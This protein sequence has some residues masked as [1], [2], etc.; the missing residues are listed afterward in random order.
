MKKYVFMIARLSEGVP[1]LIAFPPE[2]EADALAGSCVCVNPDTSCK[3]LPGVTYG[4]TLTPFTQNS[5][6]LV[7]S[8]IM[9][10]S[11]GN[12]SQG[13]TALN[14]SDN[15]EEFSVDTYSELKEILL[16]RYNGDLSVVS[17][18]GRNKRSQEPTLEKF[19]T[20]V[21]AQ[22]AVDDIIKQDGAYR[23]LPYMRRSILLLLQEDSSIW[24]VLTDIEQAWVKTFSEGATAVRMF[25]FKDT[26]ER[27]AEILN[28]DIA[29][30]DITTPILV[31]FVNHLKIEETSEEYLAK[32]KAVVESRGD[33]QQA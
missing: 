24:S 28:K 7:T 25:F 17:F 6:S 15:A 1:V 26:A 9:S 21:T 10:T 22:V 23:Y 14:R 12:P 2:D 33:S 30:S 4:L 31:A 18:L 29:G 13:F 11:D 5:C 32:V 16:C 20:F 19:F 3:R 27:I 8:D